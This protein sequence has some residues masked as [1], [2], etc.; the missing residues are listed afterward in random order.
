MK[1]NHYGAAVVHALSPLAETPCHSFRCCLR[2]ILT[3]MMSPMR[4]AAHPRRPPLL[5]R[6]LGLP[7]PPCLLL[8]SS[9][10]PIPTLLL[11]RFPST[12]GTACILGAAAGSPHMACPEADPRLSASCTRS[13]A[14]WTCSASAATIPGEDATPSLALAR[15]GSYRR[16]AVACTKSPAWSRSFANSLRG[17]ATTP[18]TAVKAAQPPCAVATRLMAWSG[19]SP[20][21]ATLQGGAQSTPGVACRAAW[22]LAATSIGSLASST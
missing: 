2:R 11:L 18:L 5:L 7:P 20:R 19:R 4:M 10:Q 21:A 9:R 8:Q 13:P 16:T 6:P 15:Q 3:T 12:T 14:W 1:A 22:R 17:A